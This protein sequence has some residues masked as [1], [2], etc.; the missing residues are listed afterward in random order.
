MKRVTLLILLTT[1]SL[2][3]YSQSGDNEDYL[4]L[5]KR[6]FAINF[7]LPKS[8]ED[9]GTSVFAIMKI[10][11]NN[12]GEVDKL[13]FSDS[14]P[15]EFIEEMNRIKDKVNFH[16]I[17]K[18]LRISDPD[19]Q[20]LVPIQLDAYKPSLGPLSVQKDV[21]DK[22]YLFKGKTITGSYLFYERI[23]QQYFY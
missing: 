13:E 17:Y 9:V 3:G 16:A 19:I 11:F 8:L 2:T 1:L 4:S 5:F 21:L 22:L 18:D 20:V 15:K 12:K 7:R 6:S 14:A 23:S 10:G